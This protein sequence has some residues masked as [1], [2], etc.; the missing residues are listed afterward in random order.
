[1]MKLPIFISLALT[2]AITC[3]A[4]VRASVNDHRGVLLLDF[5]A[6]RA[7]PGFRDGQ[8][9]DPVAQRMM[10]DFT[11][12][13]AG[14]P[15][16]MVADIETR[17]AGFGNAPPIAVPAWMR[18]GRALLAA[19]LTPTGLPVIGYC[20]ARDYAA[21]GLLGAPAEARRRLLYPLVVQS[22]CR[23]GIP[24]GLFDAM[25]I[26]ESGYHPFIRS[27]KGALGLGQL[28]PATAAELGVDPN[29]VHGN[30]DGSARYLAAHLQEFRQPQLAL[31]AY[32]AGPGRVRKVWRVPRIRETQSYVRKILWNWHKLEWNRASGH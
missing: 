4:E 14:G 21:S 3:P 20:G 17:Q 13:T 8:G 27:S 26:Q 5:T 30:L 2:A 6:A 23:H 22:A 31:A 32:N 9:T 28:M 7:A 18:G 1:M 16:S 10:L 15:I 29:N 12:R 19:Q 25:I 24:I 11:A